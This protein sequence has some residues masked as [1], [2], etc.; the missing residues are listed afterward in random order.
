[1]DSF[2]QAG[3]YCLSCSDITITFKFFRLIFDGIKKIFILKNRI[4]ASRPLKFP[5][6]R[7]FRRF[8]LCI[9]VLEIS[10]KNWTTLSSNRNLFITLDFVY[11]RLTFCRHDFDL[12]RCWMKQRS[13]AGNSPS[14][15]LPTS[16]MS[17]TQFCHHPSNLAFLF[18]VNSYS[19]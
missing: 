5:H 4:E 17:I 11:A 6:F 10:V 3:F 16:E 2:F 8:P 7:I 15:A 9:I 1:M 19:V 18:N 12:M 14:A 13:Y